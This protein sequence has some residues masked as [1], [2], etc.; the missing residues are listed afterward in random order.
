MADLDYLA[1]SGPRKAWIRFTRGA[2][3]LPGRAKDTLTHLPRRLGE[4]MRAIPR[5]IVSV[6]LIFIRGDWA[7]R[8]SF[9][10]M[11]FGCLRRGR[12]GRGLIYLFTQI[13][14]WYYFFTFGVGW[15]SLLPTLGRVAQGEVWNEEKGIFEYTA[16]DNSM[17]VLLYGIVTLI[18]LLLHTCI[19][20]S[21]VY[22]SYDCQ[23]R[24]RGAQPVP[25]LRQEILAL[26]DRDFHRVLLFLPTVA[27]MIFTVL[28]LLFMIALAFTNYDRFHMPPGNLFTWVGFENFRAI[29]GL[30]G[31]VLLGN[32]FRS[33]LGWTLVW[34][35]F[36]TVTNY[37]LGM[38]LAILINRRGIRFKKFFRTVFVTTI[39]VPQFV[40]LL[41]MRNLLADNGLVNV[42]LSQ[43]GW[44][45]AP[46]RFLTDGNIA[47]ITVILVNMWV[48]IPYSMLITTGILMNIPADLYEASRIDGAGPVKQFTTITLPYVLFV[49][50]PYLITQFVGNI[51]NFNVIWLLTGGGPMTVDYYQ[52]GKTDLLVTWLYRITTG[53]QNYKLA[54]VIGIITFAVCATFSLIVYSRSGSAKEGKFL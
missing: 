32:T 4:M 9:G 42:F 33:I 37:A 14:F 25:T 11:G 44:I 21:S 18:I 52:G 47:R 16:G 22:A 53:E 41:F 43:M 19:Y 46:I 13:A 38:I 31:N 1:S 3:S 10:I 2:K 48:G 50:A 24:A 6:G 8:L 28:P 12:I 27:V 40:S 45:D 30:G 17:L 36:A 54:S 39:A 15:L 51:N 5:A 49:T 20:F 26:R 34:A 29:L 7:T 35:F 23:C